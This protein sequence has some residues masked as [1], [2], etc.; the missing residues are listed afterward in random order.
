MKRRHTPGSGSQ[1]IVRLLGDGELLPGEAGSRGRACERLRA[2]GMRSL[3]LEWKQ[4]LAV[5]LVGVAEGI[6][7]GGVASS[8]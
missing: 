4:N 5:N 6:L 2:I 3:G 8:L 1:A 7:E